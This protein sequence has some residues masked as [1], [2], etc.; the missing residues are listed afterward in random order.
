MGGG[1]DR[2]PVA[3]PPRP[4]PR[5]MRIHCLLSHFVARL[6]AALLVAAPT[7]ALA[8][9]LPAGTVYHGD[10]VSA[11][12][13]WETASSIQITDVGNVPFTGPNVFVRLNGFVDAHAGDLRLYLLYMPG[14]TGTVTRAVQL[15][16]WPAGESTAPR[17]FD[18]D[19]V[20]GS[21]FDATLPG[22]V[23]RPGDYAA[24]TPGFSEAFNGVPLAG[25]WT[26]VVNDWN[27]NDGAT[28]A[29]W[30]LIVAAPT[31]TAPEPATAT[32]VG[33][34][35]AIVLVAARRRRRAATAER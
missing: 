3:V 25:R 11:P 26:L 22:G 14:T 18:G 12:D 35:L 10:A 20:F 27:S 17:S 29:S 9:T 6:T 19:Y 34:G 33:G 24:F 7:V 30:D 32:L 1:T 4:R 5:P 15:F 21:G 23:V 8:Q 31:T 2:R 13:N 28:I 16:D